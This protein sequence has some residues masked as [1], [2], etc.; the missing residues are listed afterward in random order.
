MRSRAEIQSRVLKAA[1]AEGEAIAVRMPSAVDDLADVGGAGRRVA[2]LLNS[3][4]QAG[5]GDGE[6]VGG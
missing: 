1:L 4:D 6:S 5:A 2:R 3:G